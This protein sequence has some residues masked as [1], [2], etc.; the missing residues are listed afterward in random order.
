V[1]EHV[2]P[3]G[4]EPRHGYSDAI[5][6]QGL[7]VA[8]RDAR[9]VGETLI[10]DGD[11]SP[12]SFE[13]YAVERAERMRRMRICAELHTDLRCTFTDEGRAHRGAVFSHLDDDPLLA[14]AMFL[15]AFAGPEAAP[16]EAFEEANLE[17][18][19]TLA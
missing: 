7:S 19:R 11:W 14:A 6:G 15:T 16:P 9:T 1:L 12:R 3:T 8:L 10:G 5:I 17:R 13:A 2:G 18:I 4:D